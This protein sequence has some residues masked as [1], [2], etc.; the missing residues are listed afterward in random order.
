MSHTLGRINTV[1]I[2]ELARMKLKKHPAI[3]KQIEKLPDEM[4]LTSAN[5][6]K[7]IVCW[8]LVIDA[9]NEE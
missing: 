9:L 3:L 4:P 2:K 5:Y 1:G 6:T 8:D 7:L